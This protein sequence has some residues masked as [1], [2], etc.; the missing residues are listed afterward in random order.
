MRGE[1]V[2]LEPPRAIVQAGNLALSDEMELIPVESDV[3]HVVD[4]LKRIDPGLSLYFHKTKE[5]FVLYWKGLNEKAEPVEDF[6]GAYTELDGRLVNLIER[7][8]AR[9]NR[10]R[11]DLVKELDKLDAERDREAQHA[12]DERM[13]PAAEQLAHALRKDLGVKNRAYMSNGKKKRRRR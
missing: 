1:Y 4:R 5:V 12:F 9:E 6:V 8:A 7:L 13:G 3:F 2:E 11:Y 10:N